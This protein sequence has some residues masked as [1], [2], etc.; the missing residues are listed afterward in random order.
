MKNFFLIVTFSLFLSAC[1]AHAGQQSP[2]RVET[3]E[4]TIL[5]TPNSPLQSD[6]AGS[7]SS[8]HSPAANGSPIPNKLDGS[9]L[10][11]PSWEGKGNSP[12]KKTP[13]N[14]LEKW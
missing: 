14:Y 6:G 8:S 10:V 2:N 7:L 1:L 3:S 11:T 5:N 4:E 12:F 9:S 13:R